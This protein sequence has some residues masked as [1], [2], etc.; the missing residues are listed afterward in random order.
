MSIEPL[1]PASKAMVWIGW[2]LTVLPSLLLLFS[3]WMK[4][5]KS[6]EVLKAFDHLGYPSTSRSYWPSSRSAVL[7]FI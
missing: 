2:V 3:G 6:E 1:R 5:S 7:C 4:V